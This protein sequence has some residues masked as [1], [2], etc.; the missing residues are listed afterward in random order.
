MNIHDF[1]QMANQV[2]VNDLIDL[3]QSVTEKISIG[4]IDT[5]SELPFRSW[6][7][8]QVS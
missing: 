2:P 6:Y 5:V 7:S 3:A 8:W 1:I 4:A